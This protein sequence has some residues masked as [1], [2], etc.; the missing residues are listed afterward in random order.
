M[1]ENRQARWRIAGEEVGSCNCA[2][3]CP[4]QFDAPPTTGWCEGF[5][6]WAIHEGHFDDVGLDGVRFASIV[7][8][9]GPIEQGGGSRILIID[10]EATDEQRE[11]IDALE[12]A[13]H[14][15]IYFE[16]FAATAPNRLPVAIAPIEIETDRERR[17]GV[18]ADRGARR[19]R[20]SNRSGM[21]RRRGAPGK[22]VLPDGFEFTEAEMARAR[23]GVKKR[24]TCQNG[25]PL[26]PLVGI[27]RIDAAQ[28]GFGVT[29]S[30]GGRRVAGPR[31]HA[32]AGSAPR[33]ARIRRRLGT[34]R[35]LGAGIERLGRALDGVAVGGE[36]G[37]VEV[38]LGAGSGSKLP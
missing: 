34:E 21:L 13:D 15:G 25:W 31:A 29:V 38:A 1:S 20:R 16:V 4:C 6:S 32:W 11:A 12:R 24:S 35:P 9:P 2:W 14:G 22:I 37:L 8:W 30:F 19:G 7:H 17:V 18:R 23:S 28:E 36:G 5:A 26:K 27:G 3:G 10:P 33:A